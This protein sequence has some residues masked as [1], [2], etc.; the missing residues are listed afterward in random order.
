MATVVDYVVN[1]VLCVLNNNFAKVPKSNIVTVFTEFYSEDEMVDAKK[2]LLEQADALITPKAD[3]LKKIKPRVGDGKLRRDVDDVLA[4]FTIMDNRKVVMPRFLAADT[5]RIPSF[6][7]ID[8]YKISAHVVGLETK[9]SEVN[10]KMDAQAASIAALM[11]QSTSAASSS[12]TA[13]IATKVSEISA[14]IDSQA[15]AITSLSLQASEKTSAP[16]SGAPISTE[17]SSA[18]RT[19][20]DLPLAPGNAW[21][22]V[23]PGGRAVLSSAVPAESRPPPP[24]QP[25]RR[26]VFGTMATA[27][28]SSKITASRS[29]ADKTWTVYIGRLNKD[30]GEDDL[31]EHLEDMD[32]K[33]AEIRKLKATQPWQAKSSAFCVTIAHKCKDAIMSA[34]LWPDNVEVRDWFYK[35]K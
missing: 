32:I 31:K 18:C 21:F 14:K 33:V 15:A 30:T 13:D 29:S 23:M 24:A 11:Q 6:R 1:E 12:P 3:E 9:M 25:E 2:V 8:L 22:T 17:S 16:P 4:I 20:V 26:R 35:P 34:D 27:A 7:E 10:A 5:S 19:T 28:S